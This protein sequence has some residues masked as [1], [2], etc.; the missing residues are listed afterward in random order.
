MII[1]LNG[2]AQSGKDTV[3]D[4]LV[5]AYGFRKI[6]M[7]EILREACIALDPVIASKWTSNGS[8]IDL[9][10]SEALDKYG[11]EQ[12]KAEF[13]NFRE[14]M[15]RLGTEFAE[16]IGHPEL[17]VQ[18]LLE[19]VEPLED[20][21]MSS[22]RRWVEALTIQQAGGFIWRVDRPGTGPANDH[23]SET[24]IDSWQF[25]ARI[26]NDAGIKELLERT[27]TL[28]SARAW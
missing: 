28:L 10:Y 5:Q 1:A 4:H 23:P 15:Q 11:Y 6:G 3:A 13:P 16:A 19:R 12:C 26:N 20:V 14:F 2:Y 8:V 24:E 27:D 17:W 25:D 21:V 7:N 9:H 18:V 22:C